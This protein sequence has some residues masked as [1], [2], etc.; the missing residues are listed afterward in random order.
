MC[1]AVSAAQ[2]N[3]EAVSFWL[4][5]SNPAYENTE[6]KTMLGYVKNDIEIGG[7]LNFRGFSEGDI[8]P[9]DQSDLAIGLYGIAHF[10]EL[11][12][13]NNPIELPF[14]P[15]TLASAPY[16]GLS[17][18]FDKDGKGTS[19]NYFAG[20][21]ILDLFALLYEFKTYQGIN[22]PDAG[23]FVLSLQFKF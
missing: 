19:I 22:V 3:D 9:D 13:V 23:N 2:G 14:L 8:T 1:L 20:L 10:P 16:F 12:D 15:E 11:V 6:I 7:A 17:Y 21:R 18:L 4:M 5:G